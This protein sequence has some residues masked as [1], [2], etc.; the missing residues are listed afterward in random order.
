[1]RQYGRGFTLIE[2]LTVIAIIAILTA[3]L[4]PV[5]ASARSKGQQTVCMSN[6]RNI[7]FAIAMYASDWKYF[8][9]HS[10]S[11]IGVKNYRWMNMIMPYVKNEG[12]FKCP[13]ADWDPVFFEDGVR[14]RSDQNYGYNWQFLG[15][16]RMAALVK[17]PFR[18]YVEPSMIE[19]PAQT[20]AVADAWGLESHGTAHKSAYVVDPPTPGP[21]WSSVGGDFYGPGDPAL[22]DPRHNGGVNVVFVDGHARWMRPE[23]LMTPDNRWWNGTGL[24]QQPFPTT[25]EHQ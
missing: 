21:M 22:L 16:G 11:R 1:M 9:M 23:V 24:P 10:F 3:M 20:V 14:S 15:N 12:V 2:S 18:G 4:L 25:D 5:L 6:M 17:A 7:G 13:A 19:A 8:P